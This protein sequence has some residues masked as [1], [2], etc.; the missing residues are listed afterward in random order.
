MEKD[1]LT[2]LLLGRS[3]SNLVNQ[4]EI[5]S[6]L[7][8]YQIAIRLI[9]STT[10]DPFDG[11]DKLP[12]VAVLNL[13]RDAEHDLE[14]LALKRDRALP[15]VIL[16]GNENH[17]KYLRLALQIGARDFLSPPP[18][19]SNSWSIAWCECIK[20]KLQHAAQKGASVPS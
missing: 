7:N 4:K 5:L 8:G 16:V 18:I 19:L 6:N 2:L 17:Q 13:N 14:T 15:S 20:K 1:L 12:D 10:Q 9:P 3:E 11:I